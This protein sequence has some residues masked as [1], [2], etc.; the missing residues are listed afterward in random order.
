MKT[1]WWFLGL[2]AIVTMA[3]L[4]LSACT[5]AAPPTP[6]PTKAPP[7]TPPKAASEAT[8]P[9]AAAPTVPPAATP[10]PVP[11][12]LNFGSVGGVGS[13]G[14]FLAIDKGYF[15][16]QGIT[17]KT[18]DFRTVAEM[19]A[20]LGTGQLDVIGT[21]LSTALL[22]A[23]DRGVDLKIVADHGQ[24][25]PKWEYGWIVLRKDL[26]ESGKVKAPADLKGM[27]IAIPSQ[28]SAGDQTVQILIQQAGLGSGEVEV[29]VLPFAEQ[30]VALGNKG[31]AASYTV[32]PFIARGLQEGFSVKW[33]PNSQFFGGSTQLGTVVYGPPPLKNQDLGRRWMIAYLKGVR[34][35]GKAFSS[36]EGR[37][38]AV[39]I[40]VK[41]S[42]V[43][44][45]NL[46][47]VMEMP[48]LDPNG[49]LHKKSMDAQYKWFVD[50]GL[51]TGKKTLD[52]ILDQSFADFA[53]Q[54]L[55]KQ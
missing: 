9:P 32:E 20:P 26:A 47:N 40:L 50:K 23:A 6:T 38:E 45:P 25:L 10:T 27:K 24:S 13:A 29:V 14:V 5:T 16:E 17:V 52:D 1:R 33:I 36:G 7:A 31:I 44:E 3:A 39:Q 11:A 28:G 48:Y 22:A 18:N 46:Y 35:Y 55:G 2:L 54:R 37:Q 8:K 43:K 30:A 53:S 21:P 41:Y 42:V 12:T 19:I 34:A 15:Q 51:Y 4:V 49:L